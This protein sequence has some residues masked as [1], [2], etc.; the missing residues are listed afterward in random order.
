MYPPSPSPNI[1]SITWSRPLS[2][3]VCG[4]CSKRDAPFLQQGAPSYDR[5]TEALQAPLHTAAGWSV[6]ASQRF[7]LLRA[8][9]I[10]G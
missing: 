2:H 4:S 1:Q 9:L 10:K 3:P 7:H 8:Q 6:H 5:C